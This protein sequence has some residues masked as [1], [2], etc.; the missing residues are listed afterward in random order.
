MEPRSRRHRAGAHP[1]RHV[2]RDRANHV[3]AL[4]LLRRQGRARHPGRAGAPHRWAP[5]HDRARPD[6]RP[7]RRRPTRDAGHLAGRL[8]RP[9]DSGDPRLAGGDHLRAGRAGRAAGPGVGAERDRHR[10]SRDDPHGRRHQPLVPLRPDLPGDA[11]ADD[12]HRLPGPQRRR[13]G[14]LRRPGEGAPD[15]GLPAHGLR[16]RLAAPAAAHEPDRVLVRQ[17]QPVP[18]RHVHRRRRRRRH[19]R[20]RRQGRHGPPRPVGAARLDPELPHVR[21]QQ[22]RPRRRGGGRRAVAGRLRRRPAQVGRT[23]VRRRG[24]RGRGEPPA[25]P[26]PVAGQ[27]A[28]EQRQGQRVLPQAPARHR[29]RRHAPSRRRRRSAPRASRGPTTSRRASSTC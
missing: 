26:Q 7:V 21:P 17:H 2:D 9:L 11:R 15:H 5:R 3:A 12:D 1:A 6:A 27:P 4:R 19:R 18:V 28:R 13:L 20:L 14:A 10:R 29:Q 22:P 8:R 25:H 24:P 16:A 23:E